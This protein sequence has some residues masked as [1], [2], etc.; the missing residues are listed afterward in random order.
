MMTANAPVIVTPTA[1]AASTFFSSSRILLSGVDLPISR[2]LQHR[3]RSGGMHVDCPLV[4][5]ESI[6]KPQWTVK[7]TDRCQQ[8]S[9]EW[10]QHP[11]AGRPSLPIGYGYKEG[12]HDCT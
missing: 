8:A 7:K 10:D 2:L 5:S 9:P 3:T 6:P 1:A 12:R 4:L 11:I